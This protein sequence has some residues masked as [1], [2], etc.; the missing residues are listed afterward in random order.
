VDWILSE[1]APFLKTQ[2]IL[3]DSPQP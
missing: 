2:G 1:L 3:R